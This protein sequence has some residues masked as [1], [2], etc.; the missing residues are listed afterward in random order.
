MRGNFWRKIWRS[1]FLIKLRSWEYWPFGVFQFPFFIYWLW[2]SLRAR[3]L[4][5]FSASNPGIP[6]GGM[7]GESKYSILEKIPAHLVPVSCLIKYPSNISGLQRTMDEAGLAFPIIFKPDIGE[8]GWMVKK[9]SSTEEAEAYLK[10]IKTDFI[11]QELVDLPLEFGVYY[12]RFP[13]EEKGIVTS[14][15]VKEMLYV[16]GDGITP[17]QNLILNNDRAKLQWE[18][19][20]KK[21]QHK[22]TYVPVK[23]EKI[24]LVSIGNHC[25]GTKFLDGSYLI[26][27]KLSESFHQISIQIPGFYF[28]RFDLRVASLE[29]LYDGNIKIM[30]LNGCGAEPAHIYQ[31]GYSIWK[32]F[33]VM[34]IHMQ[35]L[36]RVSMENRKRGAPFMLFQ[37]GWNM[38]RKLKAATRK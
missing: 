35:E 36:F 6:T 14:I 10:N 23:G 22:L 18:A 11:I 19:L 2:L 8:R 27:E 21:F 16:E 32:A 31:P 25:L 17:L 29:D 28:G 13:S 37:E 7:F 24:E 33:V 1:N 9:I 34:T 4:F 3:S 26:N 20:R 30:E 15:V 5:Y 12:R 38:Y